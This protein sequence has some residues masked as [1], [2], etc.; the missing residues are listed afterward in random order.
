MILARLPKNP[1]D[2]GETVSC[3]F[4]P[5]SSSS[6]A[7]MLTR[8]STGSR[9]AEKEACYNINEVTPWSCIKRGSLT[10]GQLQLALFHENAMVVIRGGLALPYYIPGAC[11][12]ATVI[13]SGRGIWAQ[14]H[15]GDEAPSIL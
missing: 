4:N 2:L 6:I 8:L 3:R 13:P 5:S 10:D 14:N 15:N 12:A 1:G 11:V 7:A 9:V